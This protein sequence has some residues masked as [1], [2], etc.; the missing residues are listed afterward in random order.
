MAE[1]L[2]RDVLI[3]VK[4]YPNPSVKYNETVCVAGITVE[5][6]SIR[7]FPVG[8]RSLPKQQQFKKYQIVRMRICKHDS[9]TRPESYRPDEHSFE[10]RQEVGSDHG[11]RKRWQWLKPIIGPSMC[12]L[13]RMQA[14]N[15][16][17]LGCIKPKDVSDLV[18]D[19]AED[20][21]SDAKKAIMQ[22]GILFDPVS[23]KLEKIPFVFRY[24]YRCEDSKCNGHFQSI[25]DW[26]LMERY[27]KERSKGEPVF[28]A[29]IREKFFD[30]LC[31]QSKDTHFF[32]G[33]HSHYRNSFMVLGVFWPPKSNENSLF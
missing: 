24:K 18:I 9:D 31:G 20:D 25:L 29:K 8:F 10:P 27:R 19:S 21:W 33:N 15:E 22:Q 1:W 6:G 14:L 13:Q 2:T 17:S 28:R 5:E 16:T 26:E 23:E 12:E 30:Q 32:V 7:L 4:A 3:T 11:W